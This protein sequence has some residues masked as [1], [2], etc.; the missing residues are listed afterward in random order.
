MGVPRMRELT[1]SQVPASTLSALLK[2]N[3]EQRTA[4]EAILEKTNETRRSLMP[5]GPGGSPG[6]PGGFGGPQGGPQRPGGY[7]AP[8]GGP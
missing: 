2:L 6:G 8:Q 4:I 5:R 3:G 7:G 1:V